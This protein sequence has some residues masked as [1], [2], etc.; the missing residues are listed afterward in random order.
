MGIKDFFKIVA[1]NGNTIKDMGTLMT[2]KDLESLKGMKIAIDAPAILHGAIRGMPNIETMMHEGKITS[3][4]NVIFFNVM[5]FIRLGIHQVWVFD[6][7]PPSIKMGE[8]AKRKKNREDATKKAKKEKDAEKVKKLKKIA[9]KFEDYI[10]VDTQRLLTRMGITW[11]VAPEEGEAYASYLNKNGDVD[12]V[13]SL[14]ADCFMFG[15]KQVIRPTKDGKKKVYYVYDRADI[16]KQL[17][18]TEAQFLLMGICM[19]TD[20]SEKIAR[21]GAKTVVGK[22]G[23]HFNLTDA[24]KLALKYFKN[25]PHKGAMIHKSTF[26]KAKLTKFLLR[27]GFNL[28]RLA[29]H[30]EELEKN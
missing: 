29:S 13:W 3:Y 15:A 20:F 2:Q 11:V 18:I 10:Y 1:P 6:G 4:L 24:Q 19:G 16:L 25:A 27:R 8:L 30:I 28:G 26:D 5:Q 17:D 23:Q 9:Y 12:Y 21:I 22:I 14:D 7:K